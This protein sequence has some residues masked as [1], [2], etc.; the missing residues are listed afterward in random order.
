MACERE[1]KMIYKDFARSNILSNPI[2]SLLRMFIMTIGEFTVFYRSLSTCPLPIM[3]TIGKIIFFI[4]EIFV[5]LML[6][7][8]LIAMMTRTYEHIYR[9]QKEWKRQV[10]II[11]NNK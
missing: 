5:S 6:F 11:Y 8:L 4:F 3:S 2:D 1:E 9:T 7:N 10:Y